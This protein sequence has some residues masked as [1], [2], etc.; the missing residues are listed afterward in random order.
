MTRQ[1]GSTRLGSSSGG[2]LLAALSHAGEAP[3]KREDCIALID[4]RAEILARVDPRCL[5]IKS[6]TVEEIRTKATEAELLAM[7]RRLI[8]SSS[9]G[10]IEAARG[11]GPAP[12]ALR[13]TR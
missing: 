9:T 2:V 8:P 11:G 7:N 10:G 1:R 13:T 4:P 3:L 6:K 12:S 5:V